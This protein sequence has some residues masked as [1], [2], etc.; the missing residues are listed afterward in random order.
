MSNLND[1]QLSKIGYGCYGL[2]G[3]YGNK[4]NEEESISILKSAYDLGI[5]FFD[6]ASVYGDTERIVG[7]AVKDFRDKISIATKIGL[8]K[9]NKVD[10]SYKNVISSCEESLRNLNTDYI[11]LYQVH[12]DDP[13]CNVEDTLKGLELLKKQGKIKH[14]GVGHLPL[15]KIEK[16][17]KLGNLSTVLAE[18]SAA[19]FKRYQELEKL[20]NIG[21]FDIIAFSITARGL[22]TGK[23][24]KDTSFN[25]SDIRSID[26]MFKMESLESSLRIMNKLKEVSNKLNITP[27]Q[28][29]IIWLLAQPR[30]SIALTGP[31]NIKHLE[32]N[33]KVIDVSL[34]ELVIEE[35]NNFVF[36]EEIKMKEIIGDEIYGILN[37]PL[38]NDF[39]KSYNQLIYVLENGVEY[40]YLNYSET[41][42]SFYKLLKIKKGNKDIK[43]LKKIKNDIKYLIFK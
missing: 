3:A 5:R 24:T 16:Y 40:E 32:E 9:E 36:K 34:R 1:I 27:T 6:T 13:N 14:Y 7:K 35:I 4:L 39:N 30:I 37:R 28:V 10:L 25:K 12:Y 23:I 19:N 2:A 20:W 17:L 11:D 8:N 21:H 18:V 43:E 33:A 29:A 31:T 38:P 41:M 26:P 15:D 22:L 42:E